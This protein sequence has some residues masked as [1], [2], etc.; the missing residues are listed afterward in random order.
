ARDGEPLTAGQ[1]LARVVTC[2][3]FQDA[4]KFLTTSS[5]GQRGRQ[6]AILRE[7]VYAINLAMFVVITE[8]RVFFLNADSRIEVEKLI[9][10][11]KELKEVNGFNPVIIGEEMSAIDPLNPDKTMVVDSIG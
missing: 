9:G 1:T 7:G 3:N 2:N 4:R 6:R 5:R 10:W 11:Q 8:D